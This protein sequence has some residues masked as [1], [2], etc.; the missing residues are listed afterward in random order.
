M[1][2]SRTLWDR[3]PNRLASLLA[4]RRRLGRPVLDLTLSNPTQ[5]GLA[6]PPEALA[7]LGDPRG[8]AYEPDPRGLASAREAVSADFAR[9]G[10][11][12]GADRIVLCASSS[13][14][15]GWLFKLLC[16][17]G[18]SVLVPR[19]SYPLFEFLAGLES[20]AL[21][22]YGLA[23]D[24]AWHVDLA[25]LEEAVRPRTRAVVVVNPNNPTGSSL[26]RAEADRVL[27]LCERRGLCLV[28]DEV[29]A[30]YELDPDPGRVRSLADD[31]P[32]L[33]FS[34]GGLSKSCGLPQLK[35]GWIAVGGPAPERDEALSRLEIVADTYLSVGT[36]VQRA[37]PELLARLPR[38]QAPI[39]ERVRRNRAAL[40]RAVAPPCPATLLHATGG[41]SAV[42]QVPATVP[43]EERVLRLL[44][45]DG[46]LVHPGFFFDFASEAFLVVSLLPEPEAF[47][48]GI[49]RI[50]ADAAA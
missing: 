47:D 24:G 50:L 35:L 48:R 12:V 28:S 33:S 15:Y 5:A 31:G 6:A 16:D 43:E 23:Y 26:S 30:D 4:E 13:E 27:M 18:D 10:H 8:A 45:R 11:A 7:L 49:E 2:S 34:L 29:F 9:R 44:E 32:A 37:A 25:S 36:P 46:V 20:V 19:P 39:L 21:R 22:P 14:A 1:F 41:W 40:L 17:P 3:A 42:L 38:L